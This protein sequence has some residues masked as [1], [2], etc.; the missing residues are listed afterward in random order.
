MSTGLRVRY[1]SA[2]IPHT[3]PAKNPTAGVT[4]GVDTRAY[5]REV[6]VS[7]GDTGRGRL[8]R[9]VRCVAYGTN[10]SQHADVGRAHPLRAVEYGE[11]RY[12]RPIATKQ[13]WHTSRGTPSGL[14]FLE[15]G[16]E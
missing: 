13:L 3:G 9:D 5:T 16:Q 4:C 1:L 2:T 14:G 6:S 8:R 11:E 10:R 12:E 7:R 15:L